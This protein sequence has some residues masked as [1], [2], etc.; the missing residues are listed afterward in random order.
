MNMN[1]KNLY[2]TFLEKGNSP[3]AFIANVIY[4]RYGKDRKKMLQGHYNII[5]GGPKHYWSP[6]SVRFAEWQMK[7]IIVTPKN[8][9]R[10]KEIDIVDLPFYA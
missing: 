2:G 1:L 6:C 9:D 7:T 4:E 10:I 3:E 8:N 5:N